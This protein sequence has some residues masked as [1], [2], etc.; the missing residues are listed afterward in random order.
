MVVSLV[1]FGKRHCLTLTIECRHW[2]FTKENVVYAKCRSVVLREYVAPNECSLRR[3]LEI[4]PITQHQRNAVKNKSVLTLKIHYFYL[5]LQLIV[6]GCCAQHRMRH[7][8]RQDYSVIQL[9][10]GFHVAGP[11]SQSTTTSI[12]TQTDFF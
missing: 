10:D 6:D 3:H 12:I 7:I 5:N 2:C 11:D 1:I 9:G 8:A 4:F